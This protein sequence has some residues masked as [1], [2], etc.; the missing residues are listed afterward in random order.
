MTTSN[1]RLLF[2]NNVSRETKAQ[3]ILLFEP[4]LLSIKLTL[5]FLINM[6][7]NIGNSLFNKKYLSEKEMESKKREIA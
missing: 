5:L 4:F 3:I 1:T 7:Y 2:Q 6:W